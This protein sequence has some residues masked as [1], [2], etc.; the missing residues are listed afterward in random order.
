MSED[1]K[2]KTILEVS[3]KFSFDDMIVYRDKIQ[4]QGWDSAD[5]WKYLHNSVIEDSHGAKEYP[6]ILDY[7]RSYEIDKRGMQL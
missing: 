2:S 4:E 7:I 6:S 1:L 3:K 5:A